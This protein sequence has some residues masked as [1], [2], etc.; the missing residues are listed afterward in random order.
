MMANDQGAT[1]GPPSE[2]VRLR[3]S[4]HRAAYDRATVHAIL[5]AGLVVH[6]A[7]VVEGAPRILT[8]AYGR[9]GESLYLHGSS[10]SRSLLGVRS[11]EE[12][13]LSVTLVDGLVLARSGFH[14][15]MNYRSVI[16]Y[17]VL[18]EVRQPAERDHA[19]AVITDRLT[20]GRTGALRPPTRRELAATIVYAL[21]LAESS[22]KVRS[23][24]PI[25]EPGDESWPVWAGVVPVHTS[26]GAPVPA[27]DL[28]PDLPPPAVSRPG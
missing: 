14:H 25:D 7:L 18:R 6:L 3:R 19:L 13:C 28:S 11:G 23:G 24:G 22:A 16:V 9:E 12:V 26:L 15:S 8:L 10:G 5:D 2:R 20:P 17:G 21:D 4:P 1:P 27:A